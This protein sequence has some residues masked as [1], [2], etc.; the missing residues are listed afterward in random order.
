M[1]VTTA[2]VM[3]NPASSKR[4]VSVSLIRRRRPALPEPVAP[5]LMA[6]TR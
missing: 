2:K 1:A 6:V 3:R 5:D 4:L